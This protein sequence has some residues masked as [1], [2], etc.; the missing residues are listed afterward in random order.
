MA[1][2]WPSWPRSNGVTLKFEAAAAGGIPIV[3]ALREGLIAHG[4]D[5]VNGIL[6]GTCNYILTEMEAS[7]P[8]LCRCAEGSA[9]AGLCRGRSRR[10]MSAAAIPRTSWRCCRAWPS[11]PRPTWTRMTVE[12]IAHITADDIAF[13]RE[14]GFRIKLLGVA[15]R[16]GDG[17]DQQRPSRH[18]A[19]RAR[20][21][22]MSTAPPMACWWMRARPGRSSSPAAARAKRPPPRAVIADI[23][24]IARGYAGAGVRPAGRRPDAA[25][26]RRRHGA[27]CRPGICASRCWTCPAC[28]PTSPA[29]WRKPVFPSKA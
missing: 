8:L 15:R 16:V 14:F 26:A 6:N 9:G 10:W 4:V 17:I 11:A 25:E 19:P 3:K 29:S 12:G 27:R 2:R 13:A 5:A 1:R 24:E 23:V 22:P 20:R 28:W 7:G 21:W 18:G